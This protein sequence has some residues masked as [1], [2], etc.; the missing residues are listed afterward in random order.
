[1][2]ML[3][4][5]SPLK[6]K[7]PV[8]VHVTEKGIKKYKYIFFDDGLKTKKSLHRLLKNVLNLKK[9]IKNT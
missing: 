6:N 2:L 8:N 4:L 7:K 3:E 5:T 1:M 9:N